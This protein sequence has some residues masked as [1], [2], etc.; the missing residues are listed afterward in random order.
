MEQINF[1][2]IWN[3]WVVKLG[4]NQSEILPH[5]NAIKAFKEVWN[6]AIETAAEEATTELTS[7]CIRIDK[8]SILKLKV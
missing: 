4:F 3:K 5:N 7:T 1:E 6:K 2:E 8:N